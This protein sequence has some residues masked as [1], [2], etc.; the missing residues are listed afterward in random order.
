MT[1][2][3]TSGPAAPAPRRVTG[4]TNGG[5]AR[6]L[7]RRVVLVTVAALALL[8]AAAALDAWLVHRALDRATDAA[9]TTRELLRTG[10]VA[11]AL[12]AGERATDAIDAAARRTTR[13]HWRA[14][15]RLPLLGA[16]TQT[17]RAT[18]GVGEAASDVVTAAISATDGLLD[19][20][21]RSTLL[22]D[23]RLDLALLQALVWRMDDLPLAPLEDA[24]RQLAA[25]AAA[26]WTPS[27]VTQARADAIRHAD[28]LL[29][30][31]ARG[32][33][34][35]D[36]AAAMLGTD[37]PRRYL[38]AV[39]NPAELRG[40]GGLIGFLAVLD[41]TDGRPSLAE[42]D[43][44]DTSSRVDGTVLLTT[45]RFTRGVDGGTS[46]G[47]DAPA[48]FVARYGSVGGPF[49]LPSTNVDPDLPTVAPLILGQYELASGERLDGM[50]AID[51][52]G[53]Q[54]IQ[55]ALGPLDVPDEVAGFS[56][57]LPDP[58]PPERLAEI[59]LVDSYEALGGGS[60]ERRRYQ[61]EL[62]EAALAGLVDGDWDLLGLAHAAGVAVT[63]RHLQVMSTHPEEQEALEHLG[64]AGQ[65][66][67]AA[68]GDDLLAV[69][70]VNVAGNKADAHVAHR[71]R[72]DIELRR[73]ELAGAVPTIDRSVAT[74]IEV[75]NAVDLASDRYI[76]TAQLP[77]RTSE[78][79]ELDPRPGLVR[80]WWSLWLP[81]DA[82]LERAQDLDGDP[83]AVRTDEL[84]GLRVVDHV[85][86]TLNATTSGFEVASTTTVP[87]TVTDGEVAYTAVIRRQPKAVAD[88]LEVTIRA[89]DGWRITD[90]QLSGPT[91]PEV[92]LGPAPF[93]HPVRLTVAEDV[94]SVTG[95]ATAD[96]R[97]DV[98]LARA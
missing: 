7:A 39:Q 12:E 91:G 14:A 11:P 18:T 43:G 42:P 44:V 75:D 95:S 65:L 16:T 78:E 28:R 29:D 66:R 74:R 6:G 55:E 98:R 83:A 3:R 76:S 59:L 80:T 9:R 69:T 46:G 30:A 62:A 49:F 13:W 77:R 72:H 68:P 2:P 90:A 64:A 82:R 56:E 54:V 5:H 41:V 10:D 24:R 32:Q 38:I 35:L 23:G 70:A 85:L 87:V 15:E 17:V 60:G 37:G 27:A 81:I 63:S 36:V 94:V 89:P 51:P 96:V 61:A 1:D 21:G 93:E 67:V 26:G 71:L 88:Q 33:D 31:A 8:L 97:I 53:L 50:I 58:I 92:G 86:D 34:A 73:P 45:G 22:T 20:T 84:H 40:T 19:D 48:G 57:E 25:T 52:V 79:R 4:P 47:V